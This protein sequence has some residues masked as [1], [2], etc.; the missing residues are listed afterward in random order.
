MAIRDYIPFMRTKSAVPAPYAASM[1]PYN[2]L[3]TSGQ[4]VTTHEAWVLYKS[5][6]TLAKVVDLI[7]DQVSTLRPIINVGGQPIDENA[8]IYRLLQ[9]PGHGRDRRRLIKEV[10][11]QELV[12]GTGLLCLFGNVRYAPV[13]IDMFATRH[14]TTVEG[15]DGWPQT[16]QINEPRRSFVFN[17]QEWRNDMRYLAD[18]FSE[19]MVIFDSA[20]DNKGVGLSRLQAVRTDVDLKLSSL[21]HNTS[22]MQRGATLSGIL[23]FKGALSPE[24]AA[25]IEQDMRRKMTGAANAG[26]VLLTGGSDVEFKPLMQSN[27]DMDWANLVNSVDDAIVARYN[28]PTT[29]FNN[30]AQTYDNFRVAWEQFYEQAVLPTFDRVYS[31]L[32]NALSMRLGQEIVF[33]HDKLAIET[34]AAKAVDRATKLSSAQLI[35]TNEARSLVG[36]EPMIGGDQVLGPP[37][38]EPLYEDV[39]TDLVAAG[40]VDPAKPKVDGPKDTPRKI[41]S[42]TPE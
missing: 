14:M 20:G 7:A 26:G 36:Y 2:F 29:L 5:V 25:A 3:A 33:T 27:K 40:L 38:M 13:T 15:H 30:S 18:E 41:T 42:E 23:N 12:T 34:L 24:T 1:V 10:T 8:P 31:A 32:G 28:V 16:Y 17:R 21:Q 9:R 22:L 39:W 19:L 4:Q 11:V 35:T 6:G 37:G